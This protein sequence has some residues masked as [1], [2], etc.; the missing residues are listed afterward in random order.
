[1]QLYH[2][3]NLVQKKLWIA[4]LVKLEDSLNLHRTVEQ[5]LRGDLALITT[6]TKRHSVGL[7]RCISEL[8]MAGTRQSCDDSICTDAI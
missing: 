3:P 1:M 4:P 8:G 5:L 2:Q 6:I 7:Q